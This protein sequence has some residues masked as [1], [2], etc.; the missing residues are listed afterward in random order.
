MSDNNTRQNIEQDPRNPV[1]HLNA[2]YENEPVD[3][4]YIPPCGIEDA[5]LALK[6]LFFKDTKSPRKISGAGIHRS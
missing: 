6:N 3:D 5:D 1:D 4:F 2:G